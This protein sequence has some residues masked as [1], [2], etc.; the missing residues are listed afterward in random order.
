MRLLD[1]LGF[2]LREFFDEGI[3]FYAIL[4]HR[5]EQEEVTFQ[6]LLNGKGLTMKGWSKVVG[7]C[8]QAAK[9]AWKYAVRTSLPYHLHYFNAQ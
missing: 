2:E 4:S 5:W 6:A 1:I 7:C 3:P 9:D 8:A